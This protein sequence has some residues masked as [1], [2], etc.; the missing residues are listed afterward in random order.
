MINSRAAGLAYGLILPSRETVAGEI[1]MDTLI[2]LAVAAEHS[3]LDGVWVGESPLDRHRP[4]P[5][6]VLSAVAART[7]TIRLGTAVLLA[8]LRHPLLLA[9]QAA[10]L[11]VLSNGRLDLG[12]GAGFPLPSTERQFTT[13][14][15]DYKRRFTLLEECVIA[16]RQQWDNPDDNPEPGTR[17]LPLPAQ[18]AG[19]PIWLAGSTPRALGLVGLAADGWLPYPPNPSIYGSQLREVYATASRA[20]RRPPAAGMMVTLAIDSD[21]AT[22]RRRLRHDV[23]TYYRRPLEQVEQVQAMHAGTVMTAVEYLAEFE[24]A[25]SESIVVRL[26][27]GPGAQDIHLLAAVVAQLRAMT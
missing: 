26:V 6:V 3:G 21:P 8:P 14:G 17:P 22:A 24:Q 15:V 7:S 10:S 1:T 25:G 11:D 9:H 2:E 12:L 19:P 20:G 5:F 18:S 23:E 4:D 13:L 16:L 27:W